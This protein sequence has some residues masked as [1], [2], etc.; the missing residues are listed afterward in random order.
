VFT[1]ANHWSLSSTRWIQLTN[2]MERNPSWEA[3]SHSPSQEIPSF[4]W[5]PNV[6]YRVHQTP[7]DFRGPVL[8][9][10]PTPFCPVFLTSSS[11]FL[12]YDQEFIVAML[13]SLACPVRFCFYV[14]RKCF[15]VR[16]VKMWEW[17]RTWKQGAE[18]EVARDWRRLHNEELHNLYTSPNVIRVTKSRGWDERGM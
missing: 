15:Q 13:M 18:E 14:Y 17:E 3:D 8:A 7:L 11:L 5:N 9:S 1:T 6:H 2:S 10:H 16:R 4:S 12:C